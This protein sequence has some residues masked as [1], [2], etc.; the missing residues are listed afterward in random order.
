MILFSCCDIEL[1][2]VVLVYQVVWRQGEVVS[3][4]Q[5][6]RETGKLPS[7]IKWRDFTAH[8]VNVAQMY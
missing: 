7:K 6:F 8:V 5:T 1:F 3:I 4:E 2:Y